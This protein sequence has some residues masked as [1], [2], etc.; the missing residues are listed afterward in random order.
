MSVRM[1]TWLAKA[2]GLANGDNNPLLNNEEEK[3]QPAV[4][5]D[6]KYEFETIDIQQQSNK[7]RNKKT[8]ENNNDNYQQLDSD[9]SSVQ[10]QSPFN[11]PPSDKRP[12][13]VPP[14]RN[15]AVVALKAFPSPFKNLEKQDK[16]S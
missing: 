2:K 15:S 9:F 16:S 11:S 13:L 5:D 3:K 6:R 7:K 4:D 10:F 1:R 12:Y 8:K 14:A